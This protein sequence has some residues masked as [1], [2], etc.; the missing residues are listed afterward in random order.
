[1]KFSSYEV[2]GTATYGLA[3]GEG[4]LTTVGDDL[5]HR[6]PT[7]KDVIAGD[8]LADVANRLGDK[9]PDTD[10]ESVKMLPV[11]PNPAKIICVGL[12]YKDHI[13]ETHNADTEKPMIFCRYPDSQVGHLQAL[14]KPS[15]GE[16]YD[17]EGEMAVIIG[18]H[19]RFVE[20]EDA[21]DYICGYS[22]YNEG[23]IRDW[24]YHTKQFLPGKSFF[25]T[26]SFGPWMVCTDEIPDPTVLTLE[27][28]LDGEVMQHTTTDMMIFDIPTLIN[29]ISTFTPLNPGDVIVSGTPGGVGF[30]RDPKVLMEPGK[31]AEIEISKIGILRNPVEAA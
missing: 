16:Y 10:V 8:A 23:T 19:A 11:I 30:R 18:K 22:C 17:Y 12:N 4:K 20:K 29:Y 27:T 3:D 7:L 25:E 13:A 9:T 28:R 15:Q 14:K 31:T 6:Y 2:N 24:Q 5:A 26:G 1:M 21:L